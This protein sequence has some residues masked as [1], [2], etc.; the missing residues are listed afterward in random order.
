MAKRP[1]RVKKEHYVPQLYLREWAR[2]GGLQV[3]DKT[4]GQQFPQHTRNICSERAFYDDAELE[5]LIGDPQPLE[6]FFHGFEIAGATVLRQTLN[7]I[8]AGNFAVLS[9]SAR[10]DLAIFLGIQQLRTKRARADA[11]DLMEAIT[12]EQ[13]L[14]YIRLT[15][16][17]VPIEESWLE[18]QANERARFA[19]Q[20]HLVTDE[21][22]RGEHGQCLLPAPLV[23]SAQFNGKRLLYLGPPD[24]GARKSY[25]SGSI[26][27]CDSWVTSSVNVREQRNLRETAAHS[28]DEHVRSRTYCSVS[29]GA[30]YRPGDAGSNQVRQLRIARWKAS[31][32][33]DPGRPR[34]LQRPSSP[35][36]EP[37][38]IF[39]RWRL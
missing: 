11:G 39:S 23:V 14:A 5:T 37:A 9:E 19:A 32:H 38:G 33:A 8:R 30:R 25:G 20:L 4:S 16:P 27:R 28:S 36:V 29:V 31:E 22:A 7:S 26:T 3:F 2:R 12:K 18:I 24:R 13:F 1:A 35:A 6:K 21:E 17:D 10:V 34:V 15:Q